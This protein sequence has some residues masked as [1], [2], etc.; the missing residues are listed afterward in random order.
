MEDGASASRPARTC[1]CG[2]DRDHNLVSL[3]HDYSLVGVILLTLGSSARPRELR[4]RCRYCRQVID[5]T[6]GPER[7]DRHFQY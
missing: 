1:R 5:A 7:I 4:W 6:R 2:H 3:E